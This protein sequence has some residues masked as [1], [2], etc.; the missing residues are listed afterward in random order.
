M[1]L[2]QL[3]DGSCT[4]PFQ[5][6]LASATV[7]HCLQHHRKSGVVGVKNPIHSLHLSP[8]RRGVV[9]V[10]VALSFG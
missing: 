2:A 7:Y 5:D 10:S 8:L 3:I 9:S 1:Y 4:A 6:T